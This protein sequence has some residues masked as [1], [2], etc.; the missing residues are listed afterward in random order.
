MVLRCDFF[1]IAPLIAIEKKRRPGDVP[2]L[3]CLP[4]VR[5]GYFFQ[6]RDVAVRVN[7][8]SLTE[9]KS[10]ETIGVSTGFDVLLNLA[11]KIVGSV[12]T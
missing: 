4:I 8:G 9:V 6:E 12:S 2:G 3:L 1:W 11:G 10:G 5:N 7:A